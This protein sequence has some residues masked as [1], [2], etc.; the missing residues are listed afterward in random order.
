[1]ASYGDAPTKFE[2]QEALRKALRE[3]F[4][5][6]Q[7][8]KLPRTQKRPELDFVGHAAVTDRLNTVAPDWSYTI[9]EAKRARYVDEN[10]VEHDGAFWIR[11]TM[12]IG[13]V[14]RPEYGDGADPKEAIGNFIRRA[15]MRFGVAIDLW[16]REDLQSVSAPLG[17]TAAAR[18]PVTAPRDPAG[19]DGAGGADTN[20]QPRTGTH[21]VREK[22]AG[23][24][25]PVEAG[26]GSA[27]GGDSTSG[28]GEPASSLSTE[29]ISPDDA[30]E[31]GT[32]SERGEASAAQAPDV[33]SPSRRNCMHPSVDSHRRESDGAEILTCT[34]CHRVVEVRKVEVSA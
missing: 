28:E 24:S 22:G 12:T 32:S 15:A 16:S 8:G 19:M 1:M 7:I 5:K 29:N 6:E 20:V 9:D 13:G 34:E 30:A 10:G 33:K 25:S 21:T 31:G 17:G 23:K 3:P 18:P 14:S 4:P 2:S 26:T 11:G 27:T